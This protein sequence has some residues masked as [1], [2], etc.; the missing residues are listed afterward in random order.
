MSPSRSHRVTLSAT[1]AAEV[2]LGHL[3]I[4]CRRT[5][6]SRHPSHPELHIRERNKP[7]SARRCHGQHLEFREPVY[8]SRHPTSVQYYRQRYE[9]HPRMEELSLERTSSVTISSSSKN[10]IGRADLGVVAVIIVR[11][12]CDLAV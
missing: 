12:T 3:D 1:L 4:G 6:N 11:F 10:V 7:S 5:N 9:L 8:R 2:H